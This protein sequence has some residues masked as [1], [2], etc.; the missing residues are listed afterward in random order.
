MLKITLFKHG[1]GAECKAGFRACLIQRGHKLTLHCVLGEIRRSSKPAQAGNGWLMKVMT[2]FVYV[3]L[4]H[5][6]PVQCWNMRQVARFGQEREVESAL[7]NVV[8]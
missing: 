1:G 8:I 3:P 4:G 7:N 6:P 5:G 2:I